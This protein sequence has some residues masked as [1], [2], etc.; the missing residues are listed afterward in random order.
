MGKVGGEI[1]PGVGERTDTMITPGT[2]VSEVPVESQA[3]S[4]ASSSGH[5]EARSDSSDGGGGILADAL[6]TCGDV[7]PWRLRC[8]P[9]VAVTQQESGT[10]GSPAAY[11]SWDGGMSLGLHEAGIG[12]G[13]FR[14]FC[15]QIGNQVDSLAILL[16]PCTPAMRAAGA[17]DLVGLDRCVD[18]AHLGVRVCSRATDGRQLANLGRF[19]ACSLF[20]GCCIGP[21]LRLSIPLC[22]GML[23]G[24]GTDRWL[25]RLASIARSDLRTGIPTDGT[26][27]HPAG[28]S[29]GC[30]KADCEG[31]GHTR[32]R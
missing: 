29:T 26:V 6:E 11:E 13:V 22:C 31:S 23:D 1:A 2:D 5:V 24:F 16:E 15:T 9:E 7:P 27:G 12:I 8:L 20:N 28:K 30:S 3:A 21:T 10:R 32:K 17:K 25:V 4:G 18:M 19:F 14:D